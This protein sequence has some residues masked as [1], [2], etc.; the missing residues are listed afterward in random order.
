MNPGDRGGRFCCPLVSDG[1]SFSLTP[2]T[3]KGNAV[4]TLKTLENAGFTC[5]VKGNH[6]SVIPPGGK[7]ALIDWMTSYENANDDPHELTL[8]LY[9]LTR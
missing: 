7:M 9:S 2:S 4:T 6:V 8:L 3:T 1:I 5:I